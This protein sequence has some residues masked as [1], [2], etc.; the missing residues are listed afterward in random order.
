MPITVETLMKHLELDDA[1]HLKEAHVS[2][3][4]DRKET[5]GKILSDKEWHN[6]TCKLVGS[7]VA[8]GLDN[9]EI[10][11]LCAGFVRPGYTFEETF[12]EVQSMIDGARL[13]GFA[14]K[15]VPIKAEVPLQKGPLL[16]LVGDLKIKPID[17]LISETLECNSIIGLVGP[18]GAG[19]SFVAID[20]AM[21]IA[22]GIPYHGHD[23]NA[24]LVILCAGE[25][26]RGIPDRVDAWCM[27][28]GVEKSKARLA[29]TQRAAQLFDEV[30]LNAFYKEIKALVGQHGK[31]ELII[32]DTVARHMFG[33]DENS[34]KDM[35]ALVAT[36]DK[37]KSDFECSIMLVHH[38][39]HANQDR[40]RG[41]T[42]FKGALDTEIIVKPLSDHDITMKCDKQKD[43]PPFEQMQF[44]KTS[45][46]QSI[47]LQQVTLTSGKQKSRL[48]DNEA[49]AM[50]TFKATTSKIGSDQ[51]KLDDWRK[52]FYERHT[53]DN[54]KSKSTALLRARTKLVSMN[55]LQVKNDVYSLGDKAT[56]RRHSIFVAGPTHRIRRHDTTHTYRCVVCRLSWWA[57]F[58]NCMKGFDQVISALEKQL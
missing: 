47:I 31:P 19:K 28:H 13:K 21:S 49:L 25:G 33:L 38:T 55:I 3:Q 32:I 34:A 42:A 54:D 7:Y 41:S 8:K 10:Q 30:Y 23:V 51:V 37:L 52:E 26:F 27:H 39:G 45:V 4:L 14:P 48:T 2:R 5:R 57:S 20:M 29:I 15:A 18:S 22:T 16:T 53:G 44:V 58:W 11:T 36:V 17:P 50:K 9:S 40:A 56:Q 43:G 46:G 12:K 1:K 24:G 6:N 35:G